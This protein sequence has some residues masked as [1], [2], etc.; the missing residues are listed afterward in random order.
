VPCQP[1]LAPKVP[2]G[3]GWNS[4]AEARRLSHHRFKNS[5]TVRLCRNGRDWSAEFV[6]ITASMR[7]L[8][9]KRGMLDGEAVAHCL[10]GLPHF[11]RL[12][13]DDRL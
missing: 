7:V 11:H 3:D 2:G 9:F 6:A 12:L 1:T 5:D 10:A 4:R 13:G 8:P